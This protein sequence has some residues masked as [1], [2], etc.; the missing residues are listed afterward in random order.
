MEEGLQ[1]MHSYTTSFLIN[2]LD[3]LFTVCATRFE[4]LPPPLI[5]VH[6]SCFYDH[7]TLVWAE[8]KRHCQLSKVKHL[9]LRCSVLRPCD[10]LLLLQILCNGAKHCRVIGPKDFK[11]SKIYIFWGVCHVK[12]ELLLLQTDKIR[13]H[14]KL[15]I[16]KVGTCSICALP[17]LKLHF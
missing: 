4:V 2:I 13:L 11:L 7:N 8:C 17:A 12:I 9:S 3:F 15:K 5:L 6:V 14:L 10:F 16:S 1:G